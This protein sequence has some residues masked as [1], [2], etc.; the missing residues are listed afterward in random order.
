MK[1]KAIFFDVDGTIL[2]KNTYEA[3]PHAIEALSVAKEKGVLLF[4]A[5]GR[6]TKVAEE[7]SNLPFLSLFDG[8]VNLNGA[9][10]FVGDEIINSFPISHED[11][12]SVLQTN[13]SCLVTFQDEMFMIGEEPKLIELYAAQKTDPPKPLDIS[14]ALN[15]R[16]YSMTVCLSIPEE[17]ELN[18]ILKNALTER[19]DSELVDIVSDA[20]GK[21]VGMKAIVEKFGLKMSETMAFGD[22]YNDIEM[23]KLAGIGVAMGNACEPL[24]QV[25]DYVTTSVEE[26]GIYSALKKFSII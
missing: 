20:C 14:R 4:T 7:S 24:K 18:K 1:V 17:E 12:K 26:D 13:R 11:V 2:E 3:P 6:N 19:W 25:A 15:E 16:V 8:H 23:I 5:T 21:Q 22:S 9:L 10:T